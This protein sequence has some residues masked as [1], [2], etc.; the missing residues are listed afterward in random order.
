MSIAVFQTRRPAARDA[1]SD[2]QVSAIQAWL[3]NLRRLASNTRLELS[4]GPDE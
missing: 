2:M 1:A 3:L 4:Y